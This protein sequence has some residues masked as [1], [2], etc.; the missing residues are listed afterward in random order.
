MCHDR[1][2]ALLLSQAICCGQVLHDVL[3]TRVMPLRNSLPIVPAGLVQSCTG[4][5]MWDRLPAT[6]SATMAHLAC[7]R[8]NR[9]CANR[10][11]PA[12]GYTLVV[13]MRMLL[14]CRPLVSDRVSFE[15]SQEAV[16]ALRAKLVSTPGFGAFGHQQQQ[17]SQPQQPP[18][19]PSLHGRPPPSP[20][21]Q[22]PADPE[23]LRW[24]V[25]PECSGACTFDCSDWA[26]NGNHELSV[27]A[28]LL[29]HTKC[30]LA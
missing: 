2:V 26:C 28:L 14:S 18:H 10:L 15:L 16:E 6:L 1:T 27:H 3:H 5:T 9:S 19:Q 24:K 13:T 22:D 11:A 17:Q 8:R 4:H 7:S 21:L 20:S 12:R 29:L 30:R 25:Q 23:F